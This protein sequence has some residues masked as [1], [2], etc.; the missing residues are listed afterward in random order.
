M[1]KIL[2]LEQIYKLVEKHRKNLFEEVS[3]IEQ[4]SDFQSV[5]LGG[6][7]NPEDVKHILDLF[8]HEKVG[9]DNEIQDVIKKCDPNSSTSSDSKTPSELL[10]AITSSE[11]STTS[12]DAK[13]PSELLDAITSSEKID[14][15]AIGK[16][17]EFQD[18]IEKYQKEEVFSSGFSDSRIDP[19]MDTISKLYNVALGITLKVVGHDFTFD[20]TADF[21]SIGQFVIDNLEGGYYHPDMLKTG[22]IKDQRYASSGETMFGL[23]RLAGKGMAESSAGKV[24]W[25]EIDANSGW[26]PPSLGEKPKWKWNHMAKELGSGIRIKALDVIK[27]Y[28]QQYM[29]SNF[30][31]EELQN[32]IKNSK[33]LM[34]HFI[35][36]VWNGPWWFQEFANDIKNYVAKNPN[37]TE[38]DL[39]Q[40]VL[41][42]R[43]NYRPNLSAASNSLMQQGGKTFQKIFSSI[44]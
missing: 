33:R 19:N 15:A 37:Y 28:F 6:V 18:L 41:D 42:S 3:K 34:I 20:G 38:E 40:V 24:F 39:A 44:K 7:N 21:E 43:N 13:T 11:K 27:P 8:S 32:A 10:D 17:A 22:V 2:T 14:Y 9:M 36:A 29:K 35:Y 12:S 23:D 31:T 25:A 26:N 30:P 16:C 4:K 5:G 1:R